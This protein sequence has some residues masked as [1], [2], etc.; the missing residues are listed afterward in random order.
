MWLAE[1][2][3]ERI[4]EMIDSELTIDRALQTYLQKDILEKGL[5]RDYNRYKCEKS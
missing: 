5:I 2:G 1:V 3:N 4:N